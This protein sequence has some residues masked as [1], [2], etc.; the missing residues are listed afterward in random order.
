MFLKISDG[1]RIENLNNCSVEVVSQL[2]ALLAA[3]V[4]ARLDSARKNFYQVDHAGRVFFFHAFPVG[5]K[6]MLLA[7]WPAELAVSA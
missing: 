2:E 6:V 3:G 5:G 1:L 7:S 4:E